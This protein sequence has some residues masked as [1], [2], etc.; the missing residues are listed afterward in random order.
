M[1]AKRQPIQ[2]G[3]G[4][5]PGA[6]VAAWRRMSEL[7]CQRRQACSSVRDMCPSCAEYE[8]LRF[9]VV[10]LLEVRPWT[11]VE[12]EVERYS[13][14]SHAAG[15]AGIPQWRR[16]IIADWSNVRL[17]ADVDQDEDV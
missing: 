8:E 5:A 7:R 12:M 9:R 6:A 10:E 3:P 4:R 14:L 16:T 17:L 15:F 13:E 11:D 2:R 1:T